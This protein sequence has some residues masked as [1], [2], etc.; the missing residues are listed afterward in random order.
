MILTGVKNTYAQFGSTVAG[1]FTGKGNFTYWLASLG[2]VGALGYI[3]ALREFS[4]YFMALIIIAMVLANKGLFAQL[5]A[6]LQN[7]PKAPNAV[8]DPGASTAAYLASTVGTPAAANS[9]VQAQTAAVAANPPGS[10]Q[11]FG[12]LLQSLNPFA[13]TPAY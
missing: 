3:D 4:R 12:S 9:D 5:T 1:D 10:Q 7:G 11:T 8:A 2:A 6:F 13:S